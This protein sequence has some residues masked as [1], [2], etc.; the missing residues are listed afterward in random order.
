M[1]WNPLKKL[2]KS[3]SMVGSQQV[4]NINDNIET[5]ISA[6]N[7][8]EVTTKKLYKECKR[9]N[10]C[11]LSVNRFESK[12]TTD[13]S[14]SVLCQEDSQLRQVVEEWHTFTIES[15]KNGEELAT[16][17]RK[18]VIEPLK[19]WQM[20]FIE[21]RAA[22]KKYEQMRCDLQKLNQKKQKYTEKEKTS[23]N[24]VKLMNITEKLSN[25]QQDYNIETQVLNRDI[26]LFI[27]SRVDYFQPSLAALIRS[28][29]QYWGS[30]VTS[31]KE[32]NSMINDKND[33]TTADYCKRQ[34]QR[35]DQINK[36]SIVS[37]D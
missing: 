11:I 28:E 36:L 32:H 21:M 20:A 7:Q 19:T 29:T 10:D 34:S 3:Q 24:I 33:F 30:N 16:I 18:T 17:M 22:I 8:A 2:S 31:F 12:M 5:N 14:N 23:Q 6:L 25:T 37:N 1:S 26:P 15:I 35:L 9:L 13:L 4:M 27:E